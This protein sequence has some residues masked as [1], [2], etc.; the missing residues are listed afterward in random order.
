V[1]EEMADGKFHAVGRGAVDRPAEE[2]ALMFVALHAKGGGDRQGVPD[3]RLLGVRCDDFDIADF[4]HPSGKRT[5]AAGED[6]VVIAEKYARR[7]A[8]CH[9]AFSPVSELR[10]VVPDH[11]NHEPD[12]KE[13]SDLL[14]GYPDLQWNLPPDYPLHENKGEV[15]TVECRYRQNVQ[16]REHHRE[17]GHQAQELR[18]A[19][20]DRLSGD[21]EDLDR[22]GNRVAE[23]LFSGKEV[24]HQVSEEGD[25][26]AD[27]VDPGAEGGAD[28]VRLL[29]DRSGVDR[30]EPDAEL[31]IL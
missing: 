30:A 8:V 16:Y 10:Y 11:K 21:V 25:L 5:D 19:E 3:G 14:C 6:S 7:R 29:D 26:L 28:R 23:L 13:E 20:L 31:A 9:Q 17:V 24:L 22:A 4:C 2:S 27:H 1:R 15:S 12:Q 18:R